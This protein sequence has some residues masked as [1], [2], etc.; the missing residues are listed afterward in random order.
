MLAVFWD[1]SSFGA[2]K[3]IP[4]LVEIPLVIISTLLQPSERK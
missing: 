4:K 1:M 2:E 3:N